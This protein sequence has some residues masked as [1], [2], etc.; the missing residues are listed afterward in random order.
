MK[1]SIIRHCV[2]WAIQHNT[3]EKHNQFDYYKHHTFI[4]QDNSVIEWG[5]NKAGSP[6]IFYKPHQK[7]HS[8]YIAYKKARG[9]LNKQKTFQVVN[10]RLNKQGNL[11]LS[12]P[13]SCCNNFLKA[14]GCKTV[15]FSTGI[16]DSFAKLSLT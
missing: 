8:E 14:M 5:Q 16:E 15:Y 13:C 7:I 10:I 11:K 3:K 9:L 6:P 2:Q 12:K 1:K 4:I